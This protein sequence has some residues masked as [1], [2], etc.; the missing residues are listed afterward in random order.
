MNSITGILSREYI[1]RKD[2]LN[3]VW[4]PLDHALFEEQI[5]KLGHKLLSFDHLY[6][7]KDS[8]QLIICNNKVL[9]YEKCKNIAIQFHIPVL[10]IDHDLKPKNINDKE[11]YELP[12]MYKIALSEKIATSWNE[13]YHK[14]LEPNQANNIELWADII[15]KTS[16]KLFQY[17]E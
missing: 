4:T 13:P 16:K 17:Y 1:T 14:I 12:A 7:G 5:K 9:F 6:F 3:I 8:P 11:K 10:V 15:F 2:K